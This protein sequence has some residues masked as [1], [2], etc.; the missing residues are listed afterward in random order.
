M[1][2][3]QEQPYVRPLPLRTGRIDPLAKAS[4]AAALS[5]FAWLFVYYLHAI[6]IAIALSGPV[7]A[8][9]L[10]YRA[11]RRITLSDELVRGRGLV[12]AALILGWIEVVVYALAAAFV[13]YLFT[14]GVGDVCQGMCLP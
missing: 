14:F 3:R 13:L 7:L 11:R 12:R 4:F 8:L 5:P 2:P 10:G 6:A 1:N 9:I